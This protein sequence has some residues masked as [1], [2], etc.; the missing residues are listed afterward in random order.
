MVKINNFKTAPLIQFVQFSDNS[1]KGQK[2]LHFNISFQILKSGVF[3]CCL[4][5]TEKV[6]EKVLILILSNNV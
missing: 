6:L 1:C 3:H 2:E 5:S 4:L